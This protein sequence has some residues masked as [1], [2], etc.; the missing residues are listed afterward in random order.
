MRFLEQ[1]L[2]L[3]DELNDGK[4]GYPIERA[5]D[6]ARSQQF[7]PGP[8]GIV[9]KDNRIV[10]RANCSDMTFRQYSPRGT[11]GNKEFVIMPGPFLTFVLGTQVLLVAA[12]DLPR[13]NAEATCRASEKELLNLFGDKS[14]ATYDSCMK[15]ENDSL[16]LIKKDWGSFT[17]TDRQHC[18]QPKSYMPSYVEWLTCLEM[19]RQVRDLRTKE[20][21]A[22]RSQN[23]RA[24]RR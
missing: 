7:T 15:S 22:N 11:R 8:V 6:E 20:D 14:M 19:E 5:L 24:P 17:A 21:Q 13:I 12:N 1:A 2:T 16:E 9:P 3:A 18:I 4:T 10:L 23:T